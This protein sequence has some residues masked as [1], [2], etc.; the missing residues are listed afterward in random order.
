MTQLIE[1]YEMVALNERAL[2]QTER[3]SILKARLALAMFE[4][5]MRG[6]QAGSCEPAVGSLAVSDQRAAVGFGSAQ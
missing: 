6:F 1:L 3:R 4:R 2:D 5:A